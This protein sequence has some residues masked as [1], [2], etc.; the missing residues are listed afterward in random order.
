MARISARD[1]A[2]DS[3]STAYHN[4]SADNLFKFYRKHILKM[5]ED[6]LL[7]EINDGQLQWYIKKLLVWACTTLIPAY[8]VINEKGFLEPSNENNNR[9]IKWGTIDSYVGKY[10]LQLRRTFEDEID[11]CIAWSPVDCEC[12]EINTMVER[13]HPLPSQSHSISILIQVLH[14]R[15]KVRYVS[16]CIRLAAI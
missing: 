6:V 2:G 7:S 14:M 4:D 13:F 5:P 1:T 9:C 16:P 11:D 8:Y 3:E 12:Y 10:F 15:L